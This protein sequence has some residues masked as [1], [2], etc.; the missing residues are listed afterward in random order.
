MLGTKATL[1]IPLPDDL[2]S[3]VKFQADSQGQR[4]ARPRTHARGT[5]ALWGRCCRRSGDPALRSPPGRTCGSSG[6]DRGARE[7]ERSHGPW[8][9][10][11]VARPPKVTPGRPEDPVAR[12]VLSRVQYLVGFGWSDRTSP[13]SIPCPRPKVRVPGAATRA[14]ESNQDG[15]DALVFRNRPARPDG[16]QRHRASQGRAIG[17]S[18]SRK[19]DSPTIRSS[20]LTKA[21]RGNALVAW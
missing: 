9:H 19:A 11:E 6:R 13:P 4:L 20:R 18:P 2:A 12:R 14:S 17:G 21:P 8:S 1:D 10:P 7:A 3:S 15:G 5:G 16:R